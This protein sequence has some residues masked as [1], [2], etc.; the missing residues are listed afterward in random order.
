[1]NIYMIRHGETDWNREGRRQGR[2]D[3]PLNNTGRMQIQQTAWLLSRI[4]EGVDCVI[5]SPLS[6]AMESA[7]ILSAALGRDVRD[8]LVEPLLIECSFGKTEG[9][10]PEERTRRFPHEQ[11]TA[12]ESPEEIKQR[13]T[14]ACAAILRQCPA[15]GNVL[16]VSHYVMLSA[17]V[18]ILTNGKLSKVPF[19]QG[20]IYHLETTPLGTRVMKYSIHSLLL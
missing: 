19:E 13:A 14:D 11:N 17:M 18:T 1:M 10:T 20:S 8:I 9:L 2:T 15:G 6:R 16:V 5:S 4:C 7:E 3:I 12:M